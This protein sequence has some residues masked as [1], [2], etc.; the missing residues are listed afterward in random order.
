MNT[1]LG[2]WSRVC[3][4]RAAAAADPRKPR[5]VIL[6]SIAMNGAE[7]SMFHFPLEYKRPFIYNRAMGRFLSF[8]AVLFA[9][10]PALQAEDWNRFRGPNGSGVL[11]GVT[12]PAK[13]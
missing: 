11:A 3:A 13:L 12:L 6:V 8:L 7:C 4:A 10:L 5:R 2:G 9:V 1:M